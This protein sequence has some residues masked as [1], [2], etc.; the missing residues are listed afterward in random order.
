V[1]AIT[2]YRGGALRSSIMSTWIAV[3][4]DIISKTKE[5]ASQ[6][7]AAPKAVIE[8]LNAAIEQSD[9]RKLQTF[10]SNLLKTANEQ[11]QLFAPHEYDALRRLQ[12]DRNLCAHPAF[13]VE[14]ELY[15]PTPE[16]VRSHIVHA[17]QHL[18]IHAPLQGKSA[19]ARF[20][21]DVL[22]PSFPQLPE[23]IGIYLRAKYLDRA[24][25]VL[26]KNLIKGLLT[27]PFGAEREKFTGKERLLALALREISRAKTAIYDEVVPSFASRY[28]DSVDDDVL[29]RL[30]IYLGVDPR[31]WS[32]LS[33]PVRMRLKTLLE[34]AD[35][36]TLKES[37][38]FDAFAVTDL[39]E[40]LTA[41]F[42][43][44]DQT[45]QISIIS[46]Y[47]RQEFVSRALEIY[48]NARSYRSAEALGHM[49]IV[50]LAPYFK[51]E[52][53]H[54]LL[55]KV[56]ANEQIWNAAGTPDVL[57]A[58]FDQTR[59]LLAS[60]A[61]HWRSFVED[62][63]AREGGDETAYYAFPALRAKLDEA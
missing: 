10:E 31:I 19:V 20:E 58:V 5:L 24:K 1:E 40:I 35:L 45:T 48:G 59:A 29:L 18:L 23:D 42:D 54:D 53:I 32:W 61:D 22:S 16:L 12:E 11:L 9:V 27:T 34:S 2:A 57:V 46:K 26:V 8:E 51:A 36:E 21:T 41:R 55:K 50:R 3:A 6:G 44:F 4:Y 39:A 15:Q 28:F 7:E 52:D 56:A 43:A 47:P 33:E 17:L 38:A 30:C 13:V 49:L 63:T 25:D 14:D 60:T 37:Y 62:M